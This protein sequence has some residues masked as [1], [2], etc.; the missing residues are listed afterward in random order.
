MV[1]EKVLSGKYKDC[2]I[3]YDH[4]KNTDGNDIYFNSFSVMNFEPA[5]QSKADYWS[6]QSLRV[7]GTMS[8]DSEKDQ[9]WISV[10]WRNG[11]DSLLQV[12]TKTYNRLMEAMFGRAP[13][14]QVDVVK[15]TEKK[16]NKKAVF[17]IAVI[18]IGIALKFF[19][20]N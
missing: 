12:N 5:D 10:K 15:T 19:V 6:N 1:K 16:S 4:I 14:E 8:G 20:F 7:D 13:Q 2:S 11:E 17:F 18:L 9:R 3:I